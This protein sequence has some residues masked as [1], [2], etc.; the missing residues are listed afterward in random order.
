MPT[1]IFGRR[2]RVH[3]E[4]TGILTFAQYQQSVLDE[5]RGYALYGNVTGGFGAAAP[6]VVST[7]ANS[8][9][10]SLRDALTG[11]SNRWIVFDPTVFPP[12]SETTINLSSTIDMRNNNNITIDGYGA[13]VR[14]TGFGITTAQFTGP[15]SGAI[16]VSNNLIFNNIKITNISLG[17]AWDCLT[18]DGTDRAW[19]NHLELTQGGDGNLDI[20]NI[21][22]GPNPFGYMTISNCWIHD[23]KTGKGCLIADQTTDYGD[24]VQPS[25]SYPGGNGGDNRITIVDCRF[26]DTLRNPVVSNYWVHFYNNYVHGWVLEGTALWGLMGHLRAE[27]NAIDG[28]GAGAN[29]SK[30]LYAETFHYPD[31]SRDY[32]RW[33]NHDNWFLGGATELDAS[34]GFLNPPIGSLFTIPYFYAP[35]TTSSAALI[36]RLANTDLTVQG[37]AGVIKRDGYYARVGAP[38]GKTWNV[39]AQG[40]LQ[41]VADQA[42]G[43]DTIYVTGTVTTSGKILDLKN[44]NNGTGVITIIGNPGSILRGGTSGIEGYGSCRGWTFQ[45][46]NVEV[47]GGAFFGEGFYIGGMRT[48]Q[49]GDGLG[50]ANI[51][52]IGCKVRPISGTGTVQR[53]GIAVWGGDVIEVFGCDVSDCGYNDLGF[54]GGAGSGISIGQTIGNTSYSSWANGTRVWVHDNLIRN[55]IGPGTGSYD[56][57]GIILDLFHGAPGSPLYANRMVGATLI[58]NNNIADCEGRGIQLLVA[59]A[60]DSRV[61][62]SNN[63]VS[64]SIAT[65]LAGSEPIAA[66][67]GYGDG[68]CG[69]VFVNTNN[70]SGMTAGPAAYKFISFD[71]SMDASIIGVH[72]SGNIGS[73]VVFE[74]SATNTP[75]AGFT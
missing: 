67:G 15:P 60:A 26:K 44:R 22:A 66:I 71:A 75:P 72:G 23:S 70:T 35:E 24:Y 56:R 68:R 51:R 1:V 43:G 11:G 17:E 39:P 40:S 32:K 64:G 8:G 59:G 29:A 34:G 12:D 25:S 65:N 54:P 7:T 41:T 53:N 3:T 33:S 28:T 13:Q 48:D 5:R 57:N 21:F 31:S 55:V 42:V 2:A 58:D 14:I 50:C 16:N 6:T 74:S 4:P 61:T 27:W 38:A 18:I 69:N 36:A 9:T 63:V 52:I 45:N 49:G 46:L 20:T 37:R 10:G 19:F 30:G 73:P 47:D 62:V